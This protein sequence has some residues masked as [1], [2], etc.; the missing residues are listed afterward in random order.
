MRKSKF[1]GGQKLSVLGI[2]ELPIYIQN[3]L[4][5]FKQWLEQR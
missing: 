4:D 3:N 1:E 5:K 2:N